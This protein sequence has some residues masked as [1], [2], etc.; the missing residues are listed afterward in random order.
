MLWMTSLRNGLNGG[1]RGIRKDRGSSR[2]AGKDEECVAWRTGGGSRMKRKTW[3][4]MASRR[5][6]FFPPRGT[7]QVLD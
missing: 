5:F 2:R 6:E 3:L 7:V 4:A 1:E